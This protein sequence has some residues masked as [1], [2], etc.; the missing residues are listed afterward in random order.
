[1][2][3][4]L[5][6][7]TPFVQQQ[8]SGAVAGRRSAVAVFEGHPA[9]WAKTARLKHVDPSRNYAKEMFDVQRR[10]ARLAL[11]EVARGRDGE[12]RDPL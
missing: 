7:P 4:T 5:A 6:P 8:Q 9:R 3:L 10:L 1:M 12:R 2:G 11:A